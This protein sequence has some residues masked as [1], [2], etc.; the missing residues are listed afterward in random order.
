[1]PR[2]GYEQTPAHRAAISDALRGREG[3]ARMMR[4]LEAAEQID[5]ALKEG[6]TQKAVAEELGRSQA[7]VSRLL[8]WYRAKGE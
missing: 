4:H 5:A 7:W 3:F 8:T 2:Q 1:M 6:M